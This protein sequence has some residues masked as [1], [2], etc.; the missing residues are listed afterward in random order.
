MTLNAK[1][2]NEP[3]QDNDSE[4]GFVPNLCQLQALLFLILLTQIFAVIAVLISSGNTLIDWEF[5]GLFSLYCH[6]IVLT[7]AA[8]NCRAKHYYDGRSNLTISLLFIGI[9]LLVAAAYGW[10]FSQLLFSKLLFSNLQPHSLDTNL[11]LTKSLVITAI[12]SGLLLR[13]FYLQHQWRM[14]K[15]AEVNAR[16]EALQ[17][18]IRPHF[19]FN[20]MNSIASLISID[21]DKAEDAVLDLA[22]LFRATLNTQKMLIPLEEELAL[23]QRYL[24]I[25]S[26]RLGDRLKT[27]WDIQ[28]DLGKASVPPLSLQPLFENA[29]YHGIQSRVDGGTIKTRVYRQNNSL[30]ILISNPEATQTRTH[31]GNQIALD[32]IS[33]RLTGIFGHQAVIKTS[34]LDG[35]FTVTLRLPQELNHDR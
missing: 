10:G 22:S 8:L 19:L 28:P 24:N 13:Y 23:C 31:Q 18:R 2:N 4:I 12:L 27:V 20:S 5:L 21:P 16:L 29:I 6:A 11:F 7:S 14:Q 33:R 15:Q 3:V 25:E 32:N 9:C 35:H 26:L 17:A 1:T 30:Y 34:S